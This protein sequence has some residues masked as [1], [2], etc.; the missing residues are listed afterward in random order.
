MSTQ[1]VM[2]LE[3][4]VEAESGG[5]V[6]SMR[7]LDDVFS[8][9]KWRKENAAKWEASIRVQ[10]A[11]RNAFKKVLEARRNKPEQCDQKRVAALNAS[12]KAKAQR[13]ACFS[14]REK[15]QAARS[16]SPYFTKTEKHIR[17]LNWNVRDARG[18]VH[19]FRNLANWIRQNENLFEP[20]DVRWNGTYCRA[21]SGISH[22]RPTHKNPVGSWKG[23][24][25]VSIHERRFDDANDPMRRKSSNAELCGAS[26]ASASAIGCVSSNSK[27]T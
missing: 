21:H 1:T 27:K 15:A 4:T 9:V 23:W 20:N 17:A 11:R 22:L 18:R 5:A 25:W 2:S 8:I 12:D 3:R 13:I 6:S 19:Q 16:K 24:A 10:E 26:D 7:L 14:Q